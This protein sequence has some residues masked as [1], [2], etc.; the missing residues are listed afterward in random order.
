MPEGLELQAPSGVHRTGHLV[1]KSRKPHSVSQGK[2]GAVWALAPAPSTGR[3]Q[4]TPGPSQ[5]TAQPL[6]QLHLLRSIKASQLLVLVPGEIPGCGL[7]SLECAGRA[8]PSP[9]PSLG[10]VLSLIVNRFD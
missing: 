6:Q 7:G 3:G 8:Q 9:Q 2:L 5:P 1:Q 4:S 10:C